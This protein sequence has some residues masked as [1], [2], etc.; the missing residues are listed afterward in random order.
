MMLR[1]ATSAERFVLLAVSV[2]VATFLIFC[3]VRAAWAAHSA[4][5]GTEAGIKL[6]I[7]LEP[8]DANNW[9]QLGRFW[10]FSLDSS[11]A[12][13]AIQAYRQAI[14][15]DPHSADTYINLATAYETQNDI[16]DARETFLAAQR[17]YPASSEVT[18]RVGNF[19]LRQGEL[20]TAFRDIRASVESDP[21]RGAEAFSRS[22][23][24][25]PDLQTVLEQAIP[26][27]PN[28]YLDIIHDLSG[29]GRTT[30][31]LLVWDRLVALRPPPAISLREIPEL[32][33]ALR[34]KKQFA[35]AAR[36]WKQSVQLVG[37]DA[38]A[39]G[40]PRDSVLWDGGFESGFNN[41]G[42]SWSFGSNAHGVAIQRDHTEKHS[43]EASLRL[44]FDGESDVSFSDVCHL[45]PVSPLVS[46]Q[47][48]AWVR[49]REL[50]SDQGIRFSIRAAIPGATPTFSSETHGT[51]NWVNVEI[52]WTADS[53]AFEAQVC[54]VR[55]PS[56]QSDSHIR[57]AAWV[58]D[59][60]VSPLAGAVNITGIKAR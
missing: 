54:I 10:Q 39:L 29:E 32:V 12:E 38:S 50:T 56:D 55:L 25:T 45:V 33:N 57:G 18:W 40:D 8:D 27:S 47:L 15:I 1:L 11:D 7:R 21:S 24:V 23:R 34:A 53:G 22:L 42:Y 51:T 46:Y 49:T 9:F 5:L 44:T 20:P 31:A 36:V 2:L 6:A 17:A 30:E 43:G 3:S 4:E 37:M 26:P 41:A 13:K 28:V 60:S 48:S 14:A 16:P 19:F 35:D 59:V 58:D 52:P